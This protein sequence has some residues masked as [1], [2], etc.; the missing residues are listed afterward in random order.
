MFAVIFRGPGGV[1]RMGMVVAQNI[2]ST[3]PSPFFHSQLLEGVDQET[4]FLRFLSRRLKRKHFLGASRVKPQI[5]ERDDFLDIL[6][7]AVGMAQKNPATFV[8]IVTHPM[9]SDC[10][11]M[12]L[13]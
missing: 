12:C 5:F 4:V 7:D 2:Q 13:L 3:G 6:P 9:T 11:E 10:L 1:V 8:G